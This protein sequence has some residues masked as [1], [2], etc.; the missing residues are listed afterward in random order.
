MRCHDDDDDDDDDDRGEGDSGEHAEKGQEVWMLS[1]SV[2][3][4]RWKMPCS[5]ILHSISNPI[6]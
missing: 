2:L 5:T 6:P 3:H 4:R 1:G